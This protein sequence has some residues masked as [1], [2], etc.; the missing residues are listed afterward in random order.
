MKTQRLV[1]NIEWQ[2]DRGLSPGMRTAL[3]SLLGAVL[4]IA[5]ARLEGIVVTDV[6]LLWGKVSCGK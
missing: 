3:L 1:V 6:T 2:A 5:G 4:E